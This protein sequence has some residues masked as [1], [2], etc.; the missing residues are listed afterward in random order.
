MQPVIQSALVVLGL[1]HLAVAALFMF[2]P[3]WSY[4]RIAPFAPF[5]GHFLADIGAFNLPLGVALLLCARA[6]ERQRT[7]LGLALLGNL[8]HAA[9]HLRDA[10]LHFRDGGPGLPGLLLTLLPAAALLAILGLTAPP[11]LE[12]RR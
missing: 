7:L 9:S 11:R 2:A 6:P 12:R 3:D 5:N 4:A 10:G 1:G 8:A